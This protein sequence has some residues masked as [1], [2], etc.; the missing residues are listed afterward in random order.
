MGV[1]ARI[2]ICED[3]EDLR[4]TLVDFGERQGCEVE[5]VREGAALRRLLPAFRPDPVILDL[6]LPGEDGLSLAGYAA[7]ISARS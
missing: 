1:K 6:N 7:T 5:A 2:L 3:G 4:G